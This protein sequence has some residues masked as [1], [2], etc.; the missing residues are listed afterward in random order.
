MSVLNC[1]RNHKPVVSLIRRA[2]VNGAEV[3]QLHNASAAMTTQQVRSPGCEKGTIFRLLP[4]IFDIVPLRDVWVRAFC[5]TSLQLSAP[6]LTLL[7]YF[8]QI[9]DRSYLNRS[10]PVLKAWKL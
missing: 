6:L 2:K 4:G 7:Y 1:R 10:K 5:W 9:H 8:G 3:P